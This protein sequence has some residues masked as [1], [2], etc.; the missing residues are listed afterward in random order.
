[1]GAN[2][3]S[4]TVGMIEVFC[5]FIVK[6]GKRIYPKNAKCFHFFVPARKQ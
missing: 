2:P 4:A 1:M 3:K 6:N 5:R